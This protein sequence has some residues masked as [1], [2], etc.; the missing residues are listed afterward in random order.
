MTL[1]DFEDLK[2]ITID[3]GNLTIE[4][5][6]IHNHFREGAK[7]KVEGPSGIFYPVTGADGKA[8]VNNIVAGVY[9]IS[10]IEAPEG[11]VLN[12]EIKTVEVTITPGQTVTFTCTNPYPRG[13]ATL[14]KYDKDN[15]GN[16]KG[17]ATLAGAYIIYMQQKL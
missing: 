12:P 16:T 13:S 15:P 2:N 5:K 11:T 6:D 8:Y 7:F 3:I 14:S 10:E 17:D 9:T 4:K 1:Q